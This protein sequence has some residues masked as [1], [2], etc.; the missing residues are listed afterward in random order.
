MD[1][2]L[3]EVTIR[4]GKKSYFLKTTLDDESIKAITDLSADIT[5]EFEGS[6]DQENLLLLSCLQLAWLLEKLGRK[7]ERSLDDI[8]EKE[9]L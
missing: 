7:L 5:R 1:A 3:R 8:R 9:G 4:I 2:S 6:L